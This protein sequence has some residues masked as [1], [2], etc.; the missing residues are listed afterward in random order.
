MRILAVHRFQHFR[1]S[2]EKHKKQK[3]PALRWRRWPELGAGPKELRAGGD[4]GLLVLAK[5][6]RGMERGSS[7]QMP[8]WKSL[9]FMFFFF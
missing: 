7:P 6:A 4:E 2:E 8:F 5:A 3:P 1:P 9:T